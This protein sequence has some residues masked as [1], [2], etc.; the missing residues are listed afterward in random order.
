MKF[1]FPLWTV[2]KKQKLLK[3]LDFESLF[4]VCIYKTIMNSVLKKIIFLLKPN[5]VIFK[6]QK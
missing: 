3:Y 2:W 6:S 1:T 4:F 5:E